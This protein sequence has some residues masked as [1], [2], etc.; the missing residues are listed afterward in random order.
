M[1]KIDV[2]LS[3]E[4]AF[5]VE[6]ALDYFRNYLIDRYENETLFDD[7]LEKEKNALLNLLKEL[8][9]RL[10]TKMEVLK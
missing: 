7:Y 9:Q 6:E 3:M 8:K 4:E 2:E 1:N 10:E 5:L